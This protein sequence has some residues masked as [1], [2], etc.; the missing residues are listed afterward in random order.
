MNSKR[1]RPPRCFRPRGELLETRELLTIVMTPQ[2]QLMVELVNRAC[3]DPVA[4]ARRLGIDLNQ[5]VEE[6]QAISAG[7]KQPLAPHQALIDAAQ[8]HSQ[9]MLDRDYFGHETPEGLAPSDRARAAGYPSGAGENIAWSGNTGGINRNEEV[10]KRHDQ[11]VLSVGHRIN[12]MRDSWREIGPGIRYGL[13]EQYQAIMVG[14]LFGNRGGAAFITG[15]ALSDRIDRNG[16]YDIGEGLGGVAITAVH[17]ETG[18]TFS[19]T[20]GPSGGYSLQVPAGIYAVTAAGGALRE[21]ITVNDVAVNGLNRKVDFNSSGMSTRSIA[22]VAFNDDNGNGQRDADEPGLAGR[23]VYLDTNDNRTR[24]PA[25][26]TTVSGPQGRFEFV[27]LLP[28]QYTVRQTVPQGW[29]ETSPTGA[30]VVTL[31]AG[32][33]LTN[34]SFGSQDTNVSPLALDDVVSA[35]AGRPVEIDVLANDRDPDGEIDPASVSISLGPSHAAVE[36]DPA[37]GTATYRA[38]PEFAGQDS[39]RYTVADTQGR[40]SAEAVVTVEV[41]ESRFWQ[42]ADNAYDV[43]ADGFVSPVDALLVISEIN[44]AGSREI[45]SETRPP[46]DPPPYY[47]VSGD[48]FITPRDALMVIGEINRSIQSAAASTEMA[49]KVAEP[50]ELRSLSTRGSGGGDSTGSGS[51]RHDGIHPAYSGR[52]TQS[53]R[54]CVGGLAH[55]RLSIFD[56]GNAM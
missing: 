43:S 6:D 48:N 41:A 29:R 26:T 12:M 56:S 37:T 40:R 15:V 9:D 30:T 35:V 3:A 1:I 14:T 16:F 20:T 38:A 39:F 34:L 28:G 13:F 32:N 11:L 50:E 46:S 25:E 10:E 53:N 21:S 49:P 45:T 17:N 8:L 54:G 19:D 7:A 22:G 27:G 33:D 2:E 51:C 36:V 42:N 5:D 4:E 52:G 47:D 23:T 31:T 44:R 18:D 55:L 24:D